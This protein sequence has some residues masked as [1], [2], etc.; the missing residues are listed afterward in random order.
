MQ[1]FFRARLKGD[2]EVPPVNTDAF[3]IAKFVAN[4]KRTKLKFFLEVRN[5]RNFIQ[6]HIHF[7]ERAEN[8]PVVVFLFGANLETLE[9]QNGIT[10]QKGVVTGIITDDDIVPNEVGIRTV[11][12]LINVMEQEITY[13]NAHTEQN[14]AGEI[15][16]QI[17]PHY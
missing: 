8:G 9:E 1:K 7:G 17:V 11:E 2:N 12:D 3:G 10:T 15:R 5:I 13:V 6:A 16:G 14:P 4:R